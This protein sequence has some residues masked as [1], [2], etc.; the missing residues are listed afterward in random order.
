MDPYRVL[1]L[2]EGAPR[3]LVEEVYWAL[4]GR[5]KHE[6]PAER[7]F[8]LRIRELNGAYDAIVCS[9]DERSAD[10]ARRRH[11]APARQRRFWRRAAPRA[12]PDD[13]YA[14]L[15]LHEQADD[16]VIAVAS[17]F[18]INQL[19]TRP[20]QHARLLAVQAAR[21]VLLDRRLRAEYDA[22]AASRIAAAAPQAPRETAPAAAAPEVSLAERNESGTPPPIASE[23]AAMPPASI[24][25][26]SSPT[27]AA[28]APVVAPTH[29]PGEATEAPAAD[30][31][32]AGEG[33]EAAADDAPAPAIVSATDTG[34]VSGARLATGPTA[35]GEDPPHDGEHDAREDGSA[36]RRAN[37]RG[38]R[39][40]RRSAPEDAEPDAIDQRLLSLRLQ[41][42]RPAR[43]EPPPVK[44]DAD[45]A[46]A[47]LRVVAG[48]GAGACIG[49]AD[50]ES[51]DDAVVLPGDAEPC[52]R[53]WQRGAN[54]VLERLRDDVRVT[55]ARGDVPLVLLDEGDEILA[56]STVLRFEIAPAATASGDRIARSV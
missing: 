25:D 33:S 56:G 28:D 11:H 49:V 1:Q 35:P 16:D 29:E 31:I 22:A 44:V 5:A 10:P 39:I 17:R 50:G 53:I 36:H 20:D 26:A 21:D 12:T 51:P 32:P 47:R 15:H 3:D 34:A 27:P 19:R 13:L 48:P 14:L 43:D 38:W 7:D 23:P 54:Y 9:M 2:R 37:Q 18:A 8:A 24:P 45:A 41:P 55:G 6:H 42:E 4:I 46:P 40:W 30:V 52:F